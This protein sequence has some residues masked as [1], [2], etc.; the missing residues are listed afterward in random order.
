[1]AARRRIGCCVVVLVGIVGHVGQAGPIS[2]AGN[3]QGQG[4][5]RF[6]SAFSSFSQADLSTVFPMWPGAPW[7][8]NLSPAASIPM[9]PPPPVAAPMVAAPMVTAPMVA[10]PMV[11]TPVAAAAPAPAPVVL[12]APSAV[13]IPSVAAPS[14]APPAYNAF[15][16]MGTGPY[17]EASLITSGNA[18]PWYNSPQIVSLFGGAPTAQ[19]QSS[20]TS[21]VLQRVEQTFENSGISG[22][23]GPTPTPSASAAHCAYSLV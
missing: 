9:M 8:W 18:Q 5:P 20:F 16:N 22:Q 23:P 21:T 15:I 13:S 3:L 17:P 11:A 4:D 19:Q 6:A 12:P 14:P 1:M 7:T 10:T 2:P